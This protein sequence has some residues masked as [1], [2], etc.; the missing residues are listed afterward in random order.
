MTIRYW[1]CCL[2]CHIMRTVI[3][4]PSKMPLSSISNFQLETNSNN[5]FLMSLETL[6][7]TYLYFPLDSY[8][9]TQWFS[10]S[11]AQLWTFYWACQKKIQSIFLLMFYW[12][13]IVFVILR[14]N[15]HTW[16]VLRRQDWLASILRGDRTG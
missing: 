1:L 6:S 11:I 12:W 16:K 9:K 3:F 7:N 15:L 13:S 10:E 2:W 4:L 5:L 8:L 14:G